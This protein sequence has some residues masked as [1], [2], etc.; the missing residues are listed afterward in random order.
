MA[1]PLCLCFQCTDSRRRQLLGARRGH[2]LCQSCIVCWQWPCRI[3]NCSIER[4][5]FELIHCLLIGHTSLASIPCP[6]SPKCRN[7]KDRPLQQSHRRRHRRK[8]HQSDQPFRCSSAIHNREIFLLLKRQMETGQGILGGHHLGASPHQRCGLRRR[9]RS[10]AVSTG[11]ALRQSRVTVTC[12][13]LRQRN[14]CP[15]VRACVTSRL[16][17]CAL[18]PSGV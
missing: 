10:R 6:F 12:I 2:R 7:R 8:N 13:V 4:S 15:I 17:L 9:C 18:M 16:N 1:C 3:P 11:R 5:A 14:A